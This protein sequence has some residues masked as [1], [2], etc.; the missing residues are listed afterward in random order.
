[1]QFRNCPINCLCECVVVAADSEKDWWKRSFVRDYTP[2]VAKGDGSL[3]SFLEF[4]HW[5]RAGM[6]SISHL[7]SLTIFSSLSPFPLFSILLSLLLSYMFLFILHYIYHHSC[8]QIKTQLGLNMIS[9]QITLPL[10]KLLKQS[11]IISFAGDD[12]R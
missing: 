10:E 7:Y 1:M 5:G 9:G 4:K 3:N 8:S 12:T 6:L 2:V 11:F